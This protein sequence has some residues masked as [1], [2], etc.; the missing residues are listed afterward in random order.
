MTDVSPIHINSSN[1]FKVTNKQ[2]VTD[3]YPKLERL[4]FKKVTD[5]EIYYQ[6]LKHC[7]QLREIGFIG[8]DIPADL[9]DHLEHIE[10]I[11]ISG[12]K[13]EE[14][15][16]LLGSFPSVTSLQL[17]GGN[18]EKDLINRI[19]PHF[20]KL[21]EITFYNTRKLKESDILQL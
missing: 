19:G 17:E 4:I 10:K 8:N 12:E 11:Y 20:T 5:N 15:Y 21:K 2:E 3:I 9:G 7:T 14:V 18:A 16:A 1:M 13:T 6:T